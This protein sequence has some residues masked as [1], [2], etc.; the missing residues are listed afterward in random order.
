MRKIAALGIALLMI[1][2]AIAVIPINASAAGPTV[3]KI[4]PSKGKAGNPA[5]IHGKD[6]RGNVIVVK[7]GDVPAKE[8]KVVNPKIIKVTIPE[9]DATDPDP[10]FVTVEI[11]GIPIPEELWFEYRIK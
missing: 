8:V 6:L 1:M 10:I 3:D 11:D 5:V 2:L 9:K 7:F 4:T